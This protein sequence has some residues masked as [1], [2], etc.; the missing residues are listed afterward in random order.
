MGSEVGVTWFNTMGVT[1]F[2]RQ[3]DVV[4]SVVAVF[5]VMAMIVLGAS[6]AMAKPPA[7]DGGGSDRGD[8]GG[9]GADK[10]ALVC[11]E[12]T[13]LDYAQVAAGIRADAA[14][15][16]GITGAGVDVAVIDTGVNEVDALSGRVINGPDL[17]F[18]GEFENLR[19]RD[20]HGHGTNMAAIIAADDSEFGD[21]VAPGARI[22]NV[23][24]GAADGTVDVSQVIAGINWV[25]ENRNANGM[26]IRV[27]NL[28]YGTDGDQAHELDPLSFAVESAWR[29]GI[30]VV[31]A[32]GNEGR[33]VVGLANPA[34]NPYVIAV[35]GAGK[36]LE[37]DSGF[38]SADWTTKGDEIRD[39][40][41]IAPGECM[42]AAGVN[43]S[44][45]SD[46]NPAAASTV[47]GTAYLRGTGTSQSASVVSGAAALLLE[48]R[49]ELT[50]NQVKELLNSNA[51]LLHTRLKKNEDPQPPHLAGNGLLDIGAALASRTPSAAASAQSFTPATGLGTLEGARGSFHVGEPGDELTGEITAF[52][53]AWD[54]HSWAGATWSGATWSGATW[55]GAT[56][57]G[58]SWSGATWSGG[59]WSGATWSGA[60]WSGATWSGA[61]WSGAT[62]SGATWS[63][64][65]WSGATWSGNSWS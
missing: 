49:P 25:I 54:A 3:H 27:L 11:D 63:G 33:D 23:K 48:Q 64:A 8:K 50:P 15:T 26:N 57:S 44:Y 6:P 14:W 24:V 1:W 38:K 34:T 13:T 12:F 53:T 42:L 16:Q 31:V 58:G 29:H 39:P 7:K 52:G 41:L 5:L 37:N 35:G 30:V 10:D 43:G 65:T 56:W 36:S 20:L 21:G 61:T 46:S 62:W 9:G 40:D 59:S 45:L 51:R 28:A 32:A 19:H 22:V 17:S 55:S 60:T 18:D 47:G 4:V 2:R